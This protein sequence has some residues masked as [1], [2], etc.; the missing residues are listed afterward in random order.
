MGEANGETEKEKGL[1]E[2]LKSN[3]FFSSPLEGL[4]VSH[5]QLRLVLLNQ[6]R[7]FPTYQEKQ[8]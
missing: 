6:N 7:S 2:V 3:S 4:F 8:S 5:V 1:A